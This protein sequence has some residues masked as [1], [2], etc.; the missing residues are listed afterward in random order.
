MEDWAFKLSMRRGAKRGVG[1]LS[2]EKVRAVPATGVS[3]RHSRGPEPTCAV[4]R[5]EGGVKV[6]ANVGYSYT[7]LPSGKER[8]T[9]GRV[10]LQGGGSEP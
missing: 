4:A 3:D 9:K 1:G 8:V 2:L 6:E 5:K 7:T 10:C